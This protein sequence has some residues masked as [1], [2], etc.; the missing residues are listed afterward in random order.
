[1]EFT[2][3]QESEQFTINKAGQL[4]LDNVDGSRWRNSLPWQGK[5]KTE[6]IDIDVRQEPAV[7]LDG[8]ECK[9]K[10]IQGA[11]K[12]RVLSKLR[13]NGV[14]MAIS[15]E[16]ITQGTFA[17]R[18][19]AFDPSWHSGDR[20]LV[21]KFLYDLGVMHPQPYDVVVFKK[22][23]EPHKLNFIKRLIGLPGKTIAIYNG[24]VYCERLVSA[25]WPKQLAFEFGRV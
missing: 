16:A 2:R 13:N 11:K 15:V 1:M 9:L 17:K 22:P 20:V 8:V 19:V 23:E 18:Q 5:K 7:T 24:S 4:Q 3:E 21:A 10:D 25:T 6:I 14:G 12:I